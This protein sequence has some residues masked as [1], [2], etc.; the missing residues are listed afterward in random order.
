MSEPFNAVY[1]PDYAEAFNPKAI[2]TLVDP[3]VHQQS[4]EPP[5]DFDRV[6]RIIRE[7]NFADLFGEQG[8]GSAL[9]PHVR[10]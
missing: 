2:G 5:I 1:N 4:P 3:C 7:P 9:N 8:R 6:S 10:K